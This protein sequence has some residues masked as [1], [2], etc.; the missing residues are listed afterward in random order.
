MNDLNY[1]AIP[2]DD[3]YMNNP[4]NNDQKEIDVLL[5]D[6]MQSSQI[7]KSKANTELC[8][9]EPIIKIDDKPL[10]Y[11]NG[12]TTLQAQVGT[13]K[14]TFVKNIIFQLLNPEY[15]GLRLTSEIGNYYFCL[16]DFEQDRNCELPY[17]ISHITQKLNEEQ[18]K[19]FDVFSFVSVPIHN[20]IELLQMLYDKILLN[21][22]DKYVILILDTGADLLPDV[23]QSDSSTLLINELSRF[24]DIN[25]C[26][27]ICVIH[28]NPNSSKARGHFGSDIIRKSNVI[29]SLSKDK[30][31]DQLLLIPV[32]LRWSEK[33][34][35]PLYFDN[36][37]LSIMDEDSII[38]IQ[39]QKDKELKVN[40]INFIGS[41]S[42]L[43]KNAV[44]FIKINCNCSETTARQ[45]INSLIDKEL[46][47]NHFLRAEGKTRDKSLFIATD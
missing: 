14:T 6:I 4:Q 39:K 1:K 13:Y 27:I 24:K 40:L 37:V 10:V 44:D 7:I 8:T 22:P 36:Y 16:V 47:E 29:Y 45:K 42:V 38:Q 15:D 11:Q 19:N 2:M 46:K 43:F 31:T 26:S 23:N 9:Y 18:K 32:K 3:D 41:N 21:K 28:E 5:D 30:S 33:K 25:N 20:R 17:S 34:K 12:L 35:I